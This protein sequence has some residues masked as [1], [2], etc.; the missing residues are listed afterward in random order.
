[1]EGVKWRASNGG[2]QME[3]YDGERRVLMEGID[4]IALNGG[5]QMEGVEWR[6][7]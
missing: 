1:M 6:A 3:I 5:C 2:R 4:W 7:S